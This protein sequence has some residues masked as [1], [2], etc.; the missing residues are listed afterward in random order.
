MTSRRF[1]AAQ[2]PEWRTEFFYEHAVI[3][4]VD[5]IP[6]SEALV[7]KDWK[8]F[9]WPD[10]ELLFHVAIDPLEENDLASE[11]AQTARLTEMRQRFS[12]LKAGAN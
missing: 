10:F 11:T 9:Y 6:A 7:R 2:K 12:V 4:R 1:L 3:K 8:Y 5:F